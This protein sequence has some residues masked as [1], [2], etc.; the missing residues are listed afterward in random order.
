MD[1]EREGRDEADG[2]DLLRREADA[3]VVGHHRQ[4]RARRMDPRA[5][6]EQRGQTVVPVGR[7]P[8]EAAGE[9]QPREVLRRGSRTKD[10]S[11][12]VQC[13]A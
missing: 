3:R 12:A 8:H 10:R 4:E 7:P 1:G 9:H 11:E 13:G 6:A 2:A 5:R